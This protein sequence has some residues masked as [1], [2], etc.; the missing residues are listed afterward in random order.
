MCCALSDAAAQRGNAIVVGLPQ[1]LD[2]P[3]V[4]QVIAVVKREQQF[5]VGLGGVN[6]EIG[7]N[8]VTSARHLLE[9]AR[10]ERCATAS[11]ISLMDKLH[12][13]ARRI[14]IIRLG[15]AQR[16]DR[17]AG[18]VLVQEGFEHALPRRFEELLEAIARTGDDAQH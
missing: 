12:W 8:D 13:E 16:V 17:R 18:D 10:P 2:G 14:R 9:R 7:V 11:G 5:L 3:G 4:I 15:A 1:C 6:A